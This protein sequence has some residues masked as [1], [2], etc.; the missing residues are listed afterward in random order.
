MGLFT[1]FGSRG[2][3][4]SALVHHLRRTGHVVRTPAGD[5]TWRGEA[6]GHVVHAVGV[7]SDL[8]GRP[9]SMGEAHV[10]LCAEILAE[11]DFES[12]LYLSS[13][14]VYR[15]SSLGREDAAF[16]V[17]PSIPG[18]VSDL[19]KLA[20][21]SLCLNAEHP[22]VRVARLSHVVGP[23][24][25]SSDSLASVARSASAGFVQLRASP[26]ASNDYVLL[27]DVVRVIPEIALRGTHSVYNVASGEQITHRQI[28]ERL[29]EATGCTWDVVA[30]ESAPESAPVDI[31]RVQEEF[32]FRPGSVLD[33]IPALIA[34]HPR[35]PRR[36]T[37]ASRRSI[38][39]REPVV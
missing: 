32:G 7:T 30:S 28:M 35:R 22:R 2:Y 9:S 20:G 21:E 5:E 27:E 4:G 37:D 15:T 19:T 3:V 8:R 18:Q 38:G 13:T 16:I 6:L 14:R 36:V 11:G 24:D 23:G 26:D 34:E 33:Q 31:S 29:V 39:S 25:R 12:F 17:D 1:V 10:G